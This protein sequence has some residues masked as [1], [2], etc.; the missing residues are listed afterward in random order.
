VVAQVVAEYPR[1]AQH[2]IG[3]AWVIMPPAADLNPNARRLF[4]HALQN[5]PKITHTTV[6]N[7]HPSRLRDNQKHTAGSRSVADVDQNSPKQKRGT[8]WPRHILSQIHLSNQDSPPHSRRFAPEI[9]RMCL[10]L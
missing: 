9:K 5:L 2:L 6:S 7:I 4:R 1:A 3:V 10:A 8:T